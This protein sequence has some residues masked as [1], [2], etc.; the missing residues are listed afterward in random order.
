MSPYSDQKGPVYVLALLNEL[1]RREVRIVLDIII[2]VLV[3]D[4]QEIVVHLRF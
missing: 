2:P 1:C 4:D 3:V